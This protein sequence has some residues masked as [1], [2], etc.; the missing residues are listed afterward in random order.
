M[1]LDLLMNMAS[2]IVTTTVVSGASRAL[3]EAVG[4]VQAAGLELM[5][6]R[7]SQADSRPVRMPLRTT[8][9]N[10]CSKRCAQLTAGAELLSSTLNAALRGFCGSCGLRQP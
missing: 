6:V 1:A 3:L 4:D 5:P 8:A 9:C 10:R 2:S 7:P